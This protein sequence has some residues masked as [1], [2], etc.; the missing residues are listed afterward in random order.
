MPPTTPKPPAKLSGPEADARAAFARIVRALPPDALTG[1]TN[2]VHYHTMLTDLGRLAEWEAISS[3]GSS[4][5]GWMSESDGTRDRA[6]TDDEV[7]RAAS[8]C[9]IPAPCG[10]EGD[11]D[12]G[13][14]VRLAVALLGGDGVNETGAES[15]MRKK[16]LDAILHHGAARPEPRRLRIVREAIE[17]DP[18][19]QGD[20]DVRRAMEPEGLARRV[21]TRD[22]TRHRALDRRLAALGRDPRTL[23]PWAVLRLLMHTAKMDDDPGHI[24]RRV[25]EVFAPP[26]VRRAWEFFDAAA[27]VAALSKGRRRVNGRVPSA[28]LSRDVLG[29]ALVRWAVVAWMESERREREG[30]EPALASG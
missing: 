30:E 29:R 17:G 14:A 10:A 5:G 4:L 3:T 23:V 21:L 15:A 22:W 2:P 20:S 28:R 18:D 1:E 24:A 13:A 8:L 7:Q 6:T 16:V 27:A 19:V 12:A 9:G 11:G 26:A 25:A